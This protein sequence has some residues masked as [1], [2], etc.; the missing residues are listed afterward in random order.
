MSSQVMARFFALLTIVAD[1]S[2]L[3][4]LAVWALRSRSGR[5]ATSHARA[6][7][8]LAT[9]GLRLAT[10]VA[11]TCTVGSLY[12]SEVANYVPCK[13]CWYQRIA[14]YPLVPLLLVAAVRRDL[15]IRPYVVVLAA[16]GGLVSLYHVAEERIGWLQEHGVACDLANPCSFRW[17]DEFGFITIPLMAGTAFALIIATLLLARPPEELA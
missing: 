12:L 3:A 14:M 4:S 11:L 16:L 6:R 17:V 8:F 10:L 1:V 5:A 15:W 13:L 2:V 7:E 9:H